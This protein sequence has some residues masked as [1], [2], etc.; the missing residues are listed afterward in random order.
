MLLG[1]LLLIA[2]LITGVVTLV[3]KGIL[4]AKKHKK[5]PHEKPSHEK[6]S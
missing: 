3:K 4:T 6:T 2:L 5:Q 1:V